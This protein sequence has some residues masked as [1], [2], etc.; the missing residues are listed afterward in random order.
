[1]ILILMVAKVPFGLFF[2][3]NWWCHLKKWPF[4]KHFSTK[5]R[6]RRAELQHF[7]LQINKSVTFFSFP[8]FF[9]TFDA[10]PGP[11]VWCVVCVCVCVYGVLPTRTVLLIF[12]WRTGPW[13]FPL[14]FF[15]LNFHTFF[16]KQNEGVDRK[17]SFQISKNSLRSFFFFRLKHV[18]W[19]KKN[20][21]A[22]FWTKKKIPS[23]FLD[24]KKKF[25]Q[26]FGLKKMYG[27]FES[28]KKFKTRLEILFPR[29]TV[30]LNFFSSISKQF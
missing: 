10:S 18:F 3:N 17:F 2:F 22:C 11:Q 16:S 28:Q 25:E 20:F 14:N 27:S 19:P 24:E 30:S 1:M 26:V 6:C 5:T 13:G 4:L 12:I 29:L 8:I 23:V 7:L 15:N 9:N 21:H